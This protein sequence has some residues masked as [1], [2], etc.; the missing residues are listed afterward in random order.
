MNYRKEI[1]GLRAL[2]VLPV[3]LFH[4]GF[5][6]FSGGFVGVDIFFVI[7]GYLITSVILNELEQG[8]FSIINFYERRARRILPALFFIMLACIPISWFVLLPK[9]M[10]SFSK[11]LIAVPIFASNILFRHEAGYFDL[12][13]ELK[14]LLHTWS[15]AVEEQYYLIF[16]F[17]LM[18]FWKY[19]RKKILI[20]LG[21]FFL[22]SFGLAQWGTS[23]K[24]ASAYCILLARGWEL[25]AGAFAAFFLSRKNYS[26]SKTNLCEIVSEIAGWIGIALILYAIF[27]HNKNTPYPG[28][29]A[30]FPTIG[31]LLI[32]LFAKKD[33]TLGKFLGNQVFVS[34]GLISYSAY[35]WH[36]PLFAFVRHKSLMEPDHIIFSVLCILTFILAYLTWRYIETPF[37][38]KKYL[39]RKQ[40][41][42]YS[43]IGSVFFI[44]V[45]LIGYYTDGVFIKSTG[46]LEAL[47]LDNR[48]AVNYG[49]NKEC[50]GDYTESDLCRTSDNPEVLVWG[51]SFSMHLL[52]GLIAS[53]PNIKVI[54]K[55]VSNCGPFLEIAPAGSGYAQSWSEKCISIND[56]VF[57]YLKNSPNIKYVVMGSPFGQYVSKDAKILTRQGDIEDGEKNA[58]KAMQLTINRIREL[59]KTPVIFSPTPQN[60]ENIGKCLV[61]ATFLNID[62]KF[63]DIKYSDSAAQQSEVFDFLKKVEKITTVVWLSDF[64]CS[65]DICKTSKNGVL[66][67]RD[68][69]H[70]SHEGSSYLGKEMN[71]YSRL[72]KAANAKL[73]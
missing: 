71:F 28:L 43:L 46:R 35:L 57:N 69:E 30:L 21:G 54:Q 72:E 19:G 24:P 13:S 22:I 29:Y 40:I 44:G 49:L 23:A 9:D 65:S 11:S 10:Q 64:L 6:I 39:N 67:Y 68:E 1:D 36:Q 59:K 37:R 14:P 45:G 38:V 12:A 32:I 31:T 8:K 55:T 4:A 53:N 42:Q 27:T 62:N 5:N 3:I 18:F 33:T 20:I 73:P 58:F 51:D 70:L 48:I 34:F 56:K 2:A 26:E 66:F 15:L 16:P 52:D 41:F 50:D 25:L 60:G 17:L 61:K 63:C 47:E 7:S